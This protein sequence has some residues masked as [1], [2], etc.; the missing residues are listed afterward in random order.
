MK[1]IL[2]IAP[3]P[4]DE[5]IGCGGTLLRHRDH[6]DEISCVIVTK[7]KTNDQWTRQSVIAKENE[8]EKVKK[9]YQFKSF[10]RFDFV[11]TELDKMPFNSLVSKISNLFDK[12]KPEVIYIPNISDVHTDHQVVSKAVMSSSKWFRSHSIRQIKMYETLSETN[13]NFSENNDFNPNVFVE[14]TKYL[15]KKIEICKCYATEFQKHPFP[16]SE[17]SIRSLAK[18]RGSQSGFE[19]AESFKL[20]FERN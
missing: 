19:A 3:H 5:T 15:E 2:V 14:I 13:F 4:D 7:L 18:L 6:G 10:D 20:V 17:E 16:R 9:I 12:L 1:K 11:P 8:I